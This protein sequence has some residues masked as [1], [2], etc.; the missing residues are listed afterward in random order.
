MEPRGRTLL[1]V[2]ATIWITAIS[3]V[4]AQDRPAT[5]CSF[6]GFGGNPALAEIAT[7]Q[8]ATGYSGCRSDRSCIPETFAPGDPIL[9]YRVAG[10]WTCGYLWHSDGAGPGWVRS[11][12][13][14]PIKFDPQPA[15]SAWAGTWTGG[16]DRVTIQLS[17]IPGELD[18]KGEAT[19]HGAGGVDHLGDFAGA[20]AP[21]GNHLHVASGGADPCL[22]N[23]TLVGRYIVADDN[24]KCGGLNVRFWGLWKRASR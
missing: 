13:I 4:A 3:A 23:L 2:G 1:A 9:V 21:H 15:L 17:N 24:N 22:V 10:D 16:E 6:D 12:D 8:P 5:F 14:R 19:W 20:A 18:L 7:A 11:T